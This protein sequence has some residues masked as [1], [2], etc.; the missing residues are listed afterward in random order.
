MVERVSREA[1]RSN[2]LVVE[3]DDDIRRL[4][5]TALG[6][7]FNVSSVATGREAAGALLNLRPDLMLAD[8]ELPG[9]CGEALALR[10]HALHDPPEVYL[11]SGDHERLRVAR[12][13]ACATIS[14]PFSLL[15]LIDT[16]SRSQPSAVA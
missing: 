3:D 9:L 4:L 14:K 11:M 7:H 5:E 2:I 13:L 8:L 10:A 1:D 15:Q 6:E 12:R 16:L